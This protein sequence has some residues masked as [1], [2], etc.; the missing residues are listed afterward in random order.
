MK[1]VEDVSRNQQ[2]DIYESF[3]DDSLKVT[4]AGLLCC[5]YLLLE[6]ITSSLD[7]YCV[8]LEDQLTKLK[9]KM[10]SRLFEIKSLRR[11]SIRREDIT[12]FIAL[13]E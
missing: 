3:E 7:Y 6:S 2:G 13:L 5:H 11:L 8:K 1:Y 12:R 9:T 4:I 10:S